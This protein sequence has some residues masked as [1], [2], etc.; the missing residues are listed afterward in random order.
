M[1]KINSMSDAEMMAKVFEQQ[2]NAI[3]YNLRPDVIEKRKRVDEK[4]NYCLF[5]EYEQDMGFKIPYCKLTN[6]YCNGQCLEK[7]D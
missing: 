2:T 6:Q 1:N 4:R 7:E 5:I 3:L